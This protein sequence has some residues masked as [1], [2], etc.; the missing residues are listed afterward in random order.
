MLHQLKTPSLLVALPRLMDP[1]FHKSVILLVQHDKD[2][3]MGYVI[4]KPMP[5][6]LRDAAF[7]KRYQIPP[8]VPVWLGGPLGAHEGVVIH[9]QGDDPKATV[10]AGD[11]RVSSSE[12]AIDGF[13]KHIEAEPAASRR[14]GLLLHPYRFVIGYASWGPKQLENEMKLGV[15]IQQPLDEKL[16]FATPWQEI[17]VSAI[18]ELGVDLLHIAPAVQNYLS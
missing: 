2:G 11:V 4:N 12:E 13:I 10:L 8:H 6:S 3:A 17:W 16:L 7:Q 15:W 9:N 1:H 5:L 14:R 18:D